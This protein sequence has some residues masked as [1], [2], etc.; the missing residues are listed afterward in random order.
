[1][2]RALALAALVGA[3]LAPL[4]ASAASGP[5]CKGLTATIVGTSGADVIDGTPGDDVIV[6]KGGGDGNDRIAGGRGHDTASGMPEGTAW[7]RVGL[8]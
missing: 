4:N 7:T 3:V 5:Q 8:G 1:V 6:G 2:R